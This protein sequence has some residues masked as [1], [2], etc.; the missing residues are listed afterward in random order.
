MSS[1]LA[2]TAARA[3]SRLTVVAALQRRK[4]THQRLSIL[5]LDAVRTAVVSRVKLV[6]VGVVNVLT[7]V[8]RILTVVAEVGVTSHIRAHSAVM[9]SIARVRR[10]VV[11]AR[12]RRQARRMAATLVN[13]STGHTQRGQ[14]DSKNNRSRELHGSGEK[15]KMRERIGM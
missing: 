3:C 4:D 13:R 9:D 2:A 15:E 11:R 1:R 12:S 5:N 14:R 10:A 7:A 6:A 8:Q